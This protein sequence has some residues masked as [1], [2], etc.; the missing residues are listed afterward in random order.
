MD[1]VEARSSPCAAGDGVLTF[2]TSLGEKLRSVLFYRVDIAQYF[3][4]DIT[5]SNMAAKFGP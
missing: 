1:A 2:D 3:R 5:L 4:E